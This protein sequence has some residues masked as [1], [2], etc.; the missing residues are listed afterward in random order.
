MEFS[1][2]VNLI[3]PDKICVL[4]KNLKPRNILN[5]KNVNNSKNST[6]SKT[7]EKH[8]SE[9]INAMGEASAKAQ[10]LQVA[11]TTEEKLRFSDHRLYIMVDEEANDDRGAVVGILKVGYKNLFVLN[12][13]GK[14]FECFPLCVLDF[15]V[16]E[17]RQRKG[18]GHV[19]FESMLKEEDVRTCH[20]AVDRPSAKFLTF[21]NKFYLLEDP[22][23]QTNNFVLFDEFFIDNPVFIKPASKRNKEG[24][25][26]KED[27]SPLTTMDSK[28]L[29]LNSGSFQGQHCSNSLYNSSSWKVLG[30]P[31]PNY[32]DLIPVSNKNVETVQRQLW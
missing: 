7:M 22:I 26:S 23:P 25:I 6:R 14:L 31:P 18:Y 13:E 9:I 1:F 19:L 32:G 29:I 30:V 12:R 17:S 20:M 2:D 28:Q 5:K 21:L 11:I 3:L 4:D 16:H 24:E 10:N 15:Y 27:K 8:L